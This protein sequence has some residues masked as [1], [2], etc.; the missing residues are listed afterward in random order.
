MIQCGR[1]C[2]FC[3]VCNLHTYIA[4]I[5]W[6]TSLPLS[7][8]TYYMEAPSKICKTGVLSFTDADAE[9]NHNAQSRSH[10]L[11]VAGAV[12]LITCFLLAVFFCNDWAINKDVCNIFE[13]FPSSAFSVYRVLQKKHLGKL[14]IHVP[15]GLMGCASAALG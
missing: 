1:N 5:I 11:C 10:F 14:S 13:P 7:M 2:F 12:E 9:D 4:Y 6:P 3:V 8:R 15:S